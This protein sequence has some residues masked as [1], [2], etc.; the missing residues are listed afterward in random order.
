VDAFTLARIAG[1]WRITAVADTREREGC[2]S[3]PTD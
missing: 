2:G 3:P 1:G